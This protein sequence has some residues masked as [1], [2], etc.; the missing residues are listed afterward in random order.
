MYF[1]HIMRNAQCAIHNAQ[2]TMHNAHNA[3]KHIW[4]TARQD[5]RGSL[6][7]HFFLSQGMCRLNTGE[8]THCSSSTCA[9]TPID[10]IIVHPTLLK[11][12][13]GIAELFRHLSLPADCGT[14][15]TTSHDQP[16]H[17]TYDGS[18]VMKTCLC[19]KT[20]R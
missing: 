11:H 4:D 12:W 2:C 7:E 3:H 9:F 17:T 20:K 8:A 13:E 16:Q 5:A 14:V 19:L 6:M 1:M 18:S 10:L 15:H